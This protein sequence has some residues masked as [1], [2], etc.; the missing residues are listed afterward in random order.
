M[1]DTTQ[2]IC[3]SIFIVAVVE[4]I[5]DALPEKWRATGIAIMWT[6]YNGVGM[7]FGL[8]LNGI[9]YDNFQGK[10][11][12]LIQGLLTILVAIATFIVFRIRDKR[13]RLLNK[14]NYLQR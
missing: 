8:L 13:A 10:G 9:L 14:M 3:Y 1:L 11:M 12:M 7:Y 2:G 5:S 6:A 4:Y